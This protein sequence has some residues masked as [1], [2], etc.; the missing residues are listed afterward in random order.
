MSLQ[1]HVH[2]LTAPQGPLLSNWRCEVKAGQIVTLMGP[3]GCGK[4]SLLRAVAGLLPEEIRW[5]GECRLNQQVLDHLPTHLRRVGILFQDDRLFE[6]MSV[7][8][9]LLYAT[10]AGKQRDRLDAVHEALL[11]IELA[12]AAHTFPKQL[13]GGQRARVALMRALLAQPRALLLDEPF[14]ALDE[15]LRARL[16][17]KVFELLKVREIPVLM[18]T[19]DPQD[20]ADP[21]L[22]VHWPSVGAS[23]V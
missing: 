4:S 14:S 1:I 5:R 12:Q 8:D 6:H 23:D 19:H 15:Q 7:Q 21:A 22:L 3:S 20:I 17:H 2:K 9:N 13:S 10:P 11:T 18:V 16:R